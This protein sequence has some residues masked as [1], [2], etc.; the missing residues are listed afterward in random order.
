[1]DPVHAF[2]TAGIPAVPGNPPS[3]IRYEG[4]LLPVWREHLPR[5]P[6]RSLAVCSAS[7]LGLL[8][9]VPAPGLFPL[10]KLLPGTHTPSFW[11]VRGPGSSKPHRDDSREICPSS[12][13]RCSYPYPQGTDFPGMIPLFGAASAPLTMLLSSRV[14][15]STLSGPGVRGSITS[16]RDGLHVLFPETCS[17]VRS[18]ILSFNTSL[19]PQETPAATGG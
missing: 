14:A 3:K 15:C 12:I 8:P 13:S 1:M 17:G 7:S 9:M 5:L 4:I 16:V 10:P 2:P 11:G 6:P 19:S 18:Q